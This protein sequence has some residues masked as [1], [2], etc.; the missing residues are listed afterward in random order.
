MRNP[1]LIMA[2]IPEAWRTVT[3]HG[4]VK[5]SLAVVKEAMDSNE[6]DVAIRYLEKAM[7][8]A[9]SAKDFQDKGGVFDE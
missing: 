1:L 6:F 5:C 9:R 8:A 2:D 3:H 7:M 4:S